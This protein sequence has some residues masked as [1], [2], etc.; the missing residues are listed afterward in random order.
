MQFLLEK[1]MKGTFRYLL[2]NVESDIFHMIIRY[3]MNIIKKILY[4]QSW[5]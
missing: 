2:R 3:M 5:V 1:D 4:P